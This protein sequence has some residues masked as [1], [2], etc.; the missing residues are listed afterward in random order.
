MQRGDNDDD[1]GLENRNDEEGSNIECVEKPK[2]IQKCKKKMDKWIKKG[3]FFFKCG[4]LIAK[5]EKKKGKGNIPKKMK[6]CVC[7]CL[8]RDQG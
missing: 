1:E 5:W 7:T 4:K 3:K 8:K 6:K 2:D